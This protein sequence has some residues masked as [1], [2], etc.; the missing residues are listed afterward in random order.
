MDGWT[1]AAVALGVV[2]CF[3][4]VLFRYFTP[5]RPAPAGSAGPSEAR[6]V[7]ENGTDER[8]GEHAVGARSEPEGSGPEADTTVVCEACGTPNADEPTVVFCRSCLG[9]LR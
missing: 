3:G 7:S 9:R 4:V 5:D 6:D 8:A 1:F 2:L